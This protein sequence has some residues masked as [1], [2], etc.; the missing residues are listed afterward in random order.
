[1]GPECLGHRRNGDAHHAAERYDEAD[2]RNYRDGPDR[3]ERQGGGFRYDDNAF[4]APRLY[5]DPA[6]F[7]GTGNSPR[8]MSPQ[9]DAYA[10][11]N[12]RGEMVYAGNA[13][14]RQL[15]DFPGG[16]NGYG[17]SYEHGVSSNIRQR[18]F[19]GNDPFLTRGHDR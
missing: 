8:E 13:Q 16:R 7:P 9:R 1:M 11:G 4:P 19:E 5:A 12:S 2:T 18:D 14:G 15:P 10:Y 17:P 6:G 3:P